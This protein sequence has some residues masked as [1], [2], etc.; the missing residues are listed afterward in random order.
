MNAWNS[1][2]AKLCSPTRTQTVDVGLAIARAA[3]GSLLAGH[4]AQKLF[5]TFGGPGLEGT[6]RWLESMGLRPG[7]R[8]AALAGFSEFAGGAL[9][10]LGLFH[11]LGPITL[12]GA[13]IT[14]IRKVHWGK[15]IWFASGGGELPLVYS[16]IGIAL[17]L[18]GPGR[19][20][21]DHVL[22]IKMPKTVTALATTGMVAG[23][24]TANWARK[25]VEEQKPTVEKDV[26]ERPEGTED[27]I[28]EARHAA[29][30]PATS[31]Q[32]APA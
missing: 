18:A 25:R 7:T 22:K 21:L 14:A 31:H 32:A 2:R 13:M 10:A 27:R 11:P 9:T 19:Y 17:G 15:P 8:W 20:S 23:I 3:A 26:I 5:G 4:G 28:V 12:Q 29:P 1:I 6:G 16:T 30:S 24:I